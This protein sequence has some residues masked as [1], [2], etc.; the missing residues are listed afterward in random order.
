M[1]QKT[2]WDL[3][4]SHP[5]LSASFARRIVASRLRKV[6]LNSIPNRKISIAEL[7]GGDSSFAQTLYSV[8]DP[9]RYAVYDSNELALDRFRSRNYPSSETFLCDLL[10]GTPLPQA[11]FD[12]VFSIGLIE[13]FSPEETARL[14]K[15]HFSLA[16]PGGI[17]ALSFPTPTVLYRATRFCAEKLGLWRFPD[18]RPLQFQ[19]VCDSILPVGKILSRHLIRSNFLTQLL[20]AAERLR[21]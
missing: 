7:G 10:A 4:Y 12:L 8:F 3:Y 20:I 17:V 5:N 16:K 14:V 11:Q 6:L 13:H 21:S 9:V 2:D 19:E 1:M 15:L 18:E